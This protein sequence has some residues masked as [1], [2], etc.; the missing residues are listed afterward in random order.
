M[1]TQSHFI[2]IDVSKLTLDVYVKSTDQH[3]T[4]DNN[5]AGFAFILTFVKEQQIDISDALFCF[6]NT[7][8]Y[9]K[10]LAHFMQNNRYTFLEAHPLDV[11]QSLGAVRGKNDKIDAMRLAMYAYR[12]REELKP[13]KALSPHCERLQLLA[14]LRRKLVTERGGLVARRGEMTQVLKLCRQD[15]LI[16]V[17]DALIAELNKQIKILDKE[18]QLVIKSSQELLNSYTLLLSIVGVGPVVA[19]ALLIYTGNFTK[20]NTAREFAA[21]CGLI[22]Y[23]HQSGTSV[24]R[25]KKTSRLA[26]QEMKSLLDRGATSV[27]AHD[28]DMKAYYERRVKAGKAERSVINAVRCKIVDPVF[29]VIKEQ[30]PS[31]RKASDY[32]IF[33]NKA[34]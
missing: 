14:S 13:T 3:L 12:K 18:I 23:D 30:R 17:Q 33:K 2:G 16:A 8:M 6:E 7:G 10:P 34:A 9:S 32:Q 25:N 22:P 4:A 20:F 26:N 5:E 24:R 11:K 1:I 29:T 27:I 21:Y 28:E 19:T 31:I 15:V